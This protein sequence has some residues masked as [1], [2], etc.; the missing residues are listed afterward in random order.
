MF[1][2]FVLEDFVGWLQTIM[3]RGVDKYAL[4]IQQSVA[5]RLALCTLTK[6]H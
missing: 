5:V 1:Y 3:S 2:H 4:Q 6:V